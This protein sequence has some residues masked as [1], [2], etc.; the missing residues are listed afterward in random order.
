[1]IPFH[2][3]YSRSRRGRLAAEL[4]QWLPAVAGS[5]GFGLGA[6]FL[7]VN[8]SAWFLLLLL[9]PPLLYPGLLALLIDVVLHPQQSV[10]I[11]A[12]ETTLTVRVGGR[13]RLLPLDGV[14]QVFRNGNGWAVLHL[15]GTTLDIPADAIAEEQVE[16][17]KS[18][19]RK[20][21]AE[22]RERDR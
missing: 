1:M 10:E 6:A 14:F 4:P 12:D 19:A 5:L 11:D 17:L 9:L 7:T 3:R 13:E 20:A 21:A 18:F 16:F 15:D 2:L 22:R 8:S